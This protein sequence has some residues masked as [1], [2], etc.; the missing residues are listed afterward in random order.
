ML[1]RARRHEG[2]GPFHGR[3]PAVFLRKVRTVLSQMGWGNGMLYLAGRT[4]EKVSAGRARLIRYH[5]VAQ[6]VP[7]KPESRCRP[8]AKQ[9]VRLAD[10]SD[11]IKAQFPRPAHVIE[12][13]F[14]TGSSCFVAQSGD[15]FQGFLWLARRAYDEDEVRCRYELAQPQRCVWDY[16]VHVEPAFRSG[17]TFARLWDA[18]NAHLAPDG[19]RWSLS[20]I[21]AFN[22]ASLAAHARLGV[23]PLHSGTF[24]CAGRFQLAILSTA[25]FLHLSFSEL[26]RPVIRLEP[27]D[28][29]LD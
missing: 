23:R 4:L 9:V 8:S 26:S 15:T 14:R 24:L 19:I 29:L 6:P 28:R 21:S 18:A 11:P 13:R 22:P 12:H 3:L 7:E 20:R 17:R 16:D 25:P 2:Y 5:F 1:F 10:S 27:P